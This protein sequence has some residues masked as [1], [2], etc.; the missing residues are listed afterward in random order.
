MSKRANGEGSIYERK[1]RKGY[2][3][4]ISIGYDENGKRKRKTVYGKTK[5]EVKQKLKSIE[6]QIYTGDFVDKSNITIYQLAKQMLDDKYNYNEIKQSTY[7]G[8]MSTLDSMREIKNLPLQQVN[9][10]VIRNFLLNN[11][12]YSQSVLNKFYELL[13]RT[14]NEAIKRK[15]ISEN[16]MTDI[17]KPKSKRKPVKVRA[18]T[19]DE[20]K[21]LV[22][23]LTTEE[24]KYSNQMLLSLFTGM[25][26]G[27]VN[28]LMKSDIHI[29]FNVIEVNR[30]MTRGE[31]GQAVL[32]ETAKTE[33]GCRK[34]PITEEVK[35]ILQEC[36][37]YADSESGLL[38]TDNGK[39]L[40]TNQVNMEFQRTLKKYNILDETV[41][42][43]V[44]C[45]SLRHT[46]ATRCIEGGMS[47]TV[48]QT[49][50]GHTDIKVTLNTYCDAFDEFKIDNIEQ[51]NN[52]LK[53]I[54]LTI[55]TA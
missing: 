49:L 4:T 17:H 23:V 36:V 10:S 52:Y 30:T 46:Y 32:G 42:G 9:E 41:S 54:G 29:G 38:F 18:L 45:H 27:E 24:I 21:R 12:G 14:F 3:G 34:I 8:H 51:V 11:Q 26:M 39:M 43:K 35:K 6:Y 7:L 44:T 5:T 13:K 25:R 1:G 40:H 15:I 19:V 2:C 48:L 47:A 31:K 53:A 16:P 50:L 20:Q 28:A 55:E 33:A 22:A 37:E